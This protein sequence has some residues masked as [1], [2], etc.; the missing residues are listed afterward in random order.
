MFNRKYLDN[1]PYPIDLPPCEDFYIELKVLYKS[2]PG[3]FINEVLVQYRVHKNSISS[4]RL[5]W[6]SQNDKAINL[7][8]NEVESNDSIPKN[9]RRQA[10]GHLALQKA[11][12]NLA[13]GANRRDTL[14]CLSKA[15]FLNPR[16]TM[17]VTRQLIK[18]LIS[19]NAIRN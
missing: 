16:D 3:I 15:L 17:G 5:L 4:D 1:Q 13:N 19:L 6:V 10:M 9:L 18:M 7:F 11:Q 12:I 8:L 2:G 14:K